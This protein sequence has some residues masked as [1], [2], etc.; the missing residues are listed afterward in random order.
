MF[1]LNAQ[2][3][4]YIILSSYVEGHVQKN[5]SLNFMSAVGFQASEIW[6]F[7]GKFTAELVWKLFS[8]RNNSLEPPVF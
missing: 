8:G 4:F 7:F 3:N 6:I 2:N 5:S 1:L